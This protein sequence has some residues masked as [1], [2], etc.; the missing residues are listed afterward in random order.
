[1]SKRVRA[2]VRADDIHAMLAFNHEKR[3]EVM[4]FLIPKGQNIRIIE[5]EV[6]FDH[7]ALDVAIETGKVILIGYTPDITMVGLINEKDATQFSKRPI[8]VSEFKIKL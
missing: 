1:L 3:R 4:W 2:V 6:Y 8:T 7:V 5:H